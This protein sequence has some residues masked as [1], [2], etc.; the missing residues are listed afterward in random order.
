[1]TGRATRRILALA[2]GLALAVPGVAAAQ[3]AAPAAAPTAGVLTVRDVRP[4]S[5]D[6]QDKLVI[7]CE[8]IVVG[9]PAKVTLRGRF[10]TVGSK[11][12]GPSVLQLD[13]RAVAGQRVLVDVEE[14][15]EAQLGGHTQLLDGAVEV[16]Q[17]VDGVA[18]TWRTRAGHRIEIDFFPRSLRRWLTGVVREGADLPIGGHLDG[19]EDKLFGWLGLDARNTDKGVEITR[20]EQQV[21]WSAFLSTYDAPPYDGDVSREEAAGK[22]DDATFR[23]YGGDDG[24]ITRHEL[25]HHAEELN[26]TSSFSA[27][28]AGLLPGDLVVSAGGVPVRNRHELAAAW[29]SDAASVPLVVTRGAQ[30]IDLVL[31]RH[32]AP[33]T[34]PEEMLLAP[35]MVAVALVLLLLVAP[36]TGIIVVWERKVSGRM[37]SR[38]GPNRVGP[39]GWLQW[40][41]DALKLIVKEDLVPTESDALLFKLSPYLVWMG[42][43]A[44]LVVLPASQLAI[45]ADMNIGLLYLTSVTSLVVVGII[46]GGWASNSKWSLLGGMRSAAQI[47]SYEL[48]ASVAL[49]SVALMAGTLSPQGI[50]K[51]QGGLPHQWFVFANPF[52]FVAFF[53]YFISAL[54]EG[55]R[56]PFDLPEAESELVSGYNTEY[57]GFRYSI[58]SLAEWTNLYVIGGIAATMF[59][60][61]WNVPGFTPAEIEASFGLQIASLAMMLLKVTGLVF[62]IIWIRWTLPRFRVDQMMNMCW[63]FLIPISFGCFLFGTAWVWIT[64]AIPVLDTLAR[65]AMFLI[66][67]VGLGAFFLSRVRHN[68]RTTQLLYMGDSQFT[69]PFVERHLEK[70]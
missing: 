29:A 33:A 26:E 47:I 17:T 9:Q 45:V 3:G 1:M 28:A 65:W 25:Q 23:A 63:K 11:T 36:I 34:P 42:V 10:Q 19:T 56:T 39:R 61:G 22:I 6:V 14:K 18:T 44:T 20:V 67:G 2:F 51:A 40:L 30:K 62:V 12:P 7:E 55:N 31:P 64:T 57:S 49:L 54:A 5:V 58:Y 38:L 4:S 8:G 37:Q 52:L 50:V 43:F 27:A 68:M 53:V 16:V 24:R 21:D 69:L 35:L 32:G 48:P 15:L 70:R 59:L 66:F 46:M 13:G 41:A 60:G